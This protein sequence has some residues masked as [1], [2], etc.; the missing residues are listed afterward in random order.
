MRNVVKFAVALLVG[1]SLFYFVVKETGVEV[2][3][4]GIGLFLGPEG[5]AIITSTLLIVFVGAFRW[6]EVIA[7]QGEKISLFIATRYLIKGFTVDFLTPFSLFGGEAVRIFLMEG[8]LG[9]KKSAISTV[10]DKIMD[11]T[12]HFLF[13]VLGIILFFVY[14]S[15]LSGV[16]LYYIFGV[17]IFLFLIL[18]LFYQRALRKKSFLK[19]IFGMLRISKRYFSENDSGRAIMEVEEGI[20]SFF[21]AQKKD[22][23]KGMALS[24]LRHFL[25]VFRVFLIIYFL[26]GEIEPGFALV[27]YGLTILSMLLPLPAALGGMEVMVALGFGAL[28]FGFATGAAYAVTVRSADLVICAIGMILFARLSFTSFFKQL[29]LFY[30]KLFGREG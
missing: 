8:S 12:T 30:G 27:V 13:L 19:W 16:F 14:G 17:I 21:S 7:S 29:N 23:L 3:W 28:G 15:S 25:Y 18:F 26:T 20:M 9:L 5:V 6:K 10:V 24:F 11:V 1:A 22:L 4:Q 2:I